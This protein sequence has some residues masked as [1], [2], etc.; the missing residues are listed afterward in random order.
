MVFPDMGLKFMILYKFLL[1]T[2][3]CTAITRFHLKGFKDK[4]Q[5]V[6]FR[7]GSAT[8][9]QSKYH[10]ERYFD[11]LATAVFDY[12]FLDIQDD[13]KDTTFSQCEWLHARANDISW[14]MPRYNLHK[15]TKP[16]GG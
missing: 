8:T 15:C 11:D 7:V 10:Y 5:F 1:T 4:A 3:N 13:H 2:L 12:N 6:S 16:L 9:R 14:K